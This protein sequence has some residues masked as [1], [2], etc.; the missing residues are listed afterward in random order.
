MYGGKW[1]G[2]SQSDCQSRAY[3]TGIPGYQTAGSALTLQTARPVSGSWPAAQI[4]VISS[5]T[6]SSDPPLWALILGAHC[7]WELNGVGDAIAVADEAAR[8]LVCRRANML[9]SESRLGKMHVKG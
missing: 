6:C 3:I 8:V 5:I 4:A 9:Q 1:A 7:P 2:Y